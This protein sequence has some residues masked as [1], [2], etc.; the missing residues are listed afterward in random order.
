LFKTNFEYISNLYFSISGAIVHSGRAFSNDSTQREYTIQNLNCVGTEDDITECPASE[1]KNGLNCYHNMPLEIECSEWLL[2]LL[3][4]FLLAHTFLKWSRLVF[5]F[6]F[7]YLHITIKQGARQANKYF[8]CLHLQYF[9]SLF[10]CPKEFRTYY[11]I[12]PG[13]RPSVRPSVRPLA[14]WFPEH[15]FSSI[16][17]TIF[18]LHRMIVHIG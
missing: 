13:V 3:L 2:L 6:S 18:K 1:W 17:P 8:Y 16:W 4:L 7:V 9:L 14:I 15:N 12:P 5:L 11:V 10:I